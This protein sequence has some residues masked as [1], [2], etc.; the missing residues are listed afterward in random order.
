MIMLRYSL[1]ASLLLVGFRASP[2][3]GQVGCTYHMT[4]T[5]PVPATDISYQTFINSWQDTYG[6]IWTITST[7]STV[8]GSVLTT[9]PSPGCPNITFTVSGS[10]SPSLQIDGVQGTT[11]FTW[12]A[13]NPTPPSSCGGYTPTPF[14]YSG[15]IQNDGNDL[16][17][18]TTWTNSSG[19]GSTTV[20]K[21][22]SDIPTSETTNA[23]GFGAGLG[24]TV[25][26]FRQILVAAS[27]STDIFQG[28]QVSEYTGFGTN[29]DNCFFTGSMVPQWT[30]VLGSEWNV[31]YYSIA[32]PYITSLNEWADDYIGWNTA[33]VRYYRSHHGGGPPLCGARI[34]QAMYIATGGTSGSSQNYA[35]DTVGSDI[36]SDHVDVI[37][38]GVTQTAIF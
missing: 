21:S 5:N 25:G 12:N 30:S 35:N 32:P 38:A 9:N 10:I 2:A 20:T 4:C 15:T 8:S 17:P 26:Q 31:G 36:Y 6:F 7:G 1:F 37:R 3:F 18:N 11:G 19:S 13:S 28:R 33:H 34:P 27:G 14:S 29:Y 24:A 23:V 16:G 22:P